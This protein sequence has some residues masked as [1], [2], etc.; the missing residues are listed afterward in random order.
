MNLTN[1]VSSHESN[2]TAGSWSKI[3]KIDT[4]DSDL[5]ARS[6]TQEKTA[7]DHR[8]IMYIKLLVSRTRNFRRHLTRGYHSRN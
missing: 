4:P 6:D 1:C 7:S 2:K 5:K 8:R 3:P